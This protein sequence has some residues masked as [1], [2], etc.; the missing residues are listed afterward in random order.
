MT[1]HIERQLLSMDLRF[2]SALAHARSFEAHDSTM[3][4]EFEQ[5]LGE[6]LRLF[7]PGGYRVRGLLLPPGEHAPRRSAKQ[8]DLAVYPDWVPLLRGELAADWITVTFEAKTNLSYK[9]DIMSTAKKIAKSAETSSRRTPLPFFVLAGEIEGGAQWLS[10]LVA[11]IA[12]GLPDEALWPAAFVFDQGKAMSSFA[13]NESSPIKVLSATGE[14]LA[15]VVTVAAAELSPAAL[16]YLF[17]WAAIYAGDKQNS[18]YF[19][20]MKQEFEHLCASQDGIL[21]LFTAGGETRESRVFFRL[22]Q[23]REPGDS[24]ASPVSKTAPTADGDDGRRSPGGRRVML[25]TLGGWVNEPD[26]WDESQW[27]GSASST[28]SGYGYYPGMSDRALLDAC[29]LFWQFNPDS[30]AW[31]DVEYAVV[32]HDG[33]TR[34]V[35]R[36]ERYIGPF[37]GRWGFQGQV[38]TGG[39]LLRELVGREVPRRRNPVTAIDL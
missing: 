35:V 9:N 7:L 18:S 16:C 5:G 31:R 37:W 36:I 30:P 8:I 34:A 13:V 12:D 4:A 23:S 10:R 15:G 19:H 11:S 33:V 14:S 39:A 2:R 27:G 28:R 6:V 17:L 22:P 29:R 38:V 25:I 21:V 1:S 20:F 24:K 26:T 3:G 32:A